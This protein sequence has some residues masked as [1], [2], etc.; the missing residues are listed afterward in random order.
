MRKTRCKEA[1]G[2]NNTVTNLSARHFDFKLKRVNQT[3]S[4]CWIRIY[5]LNL[6]RLA[7]VVLFMQRSVYDMISNCLVVVEMLS[8]AS[9]L[10]TSRV[11]RSCASRRCYL[12]SIR[13]LTVNFSVWKDVREGGSWA[14]STGKGD[15]SPWQLRSVPTFDTLHRLCVGKEDGQTKGREK[16]WSLF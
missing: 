13:Y 3:I 10:T 6:D 4:A 8:T 16:E 1:S 15:S 11:P 5:G 12:A 2:S 9:T 14:L 7:V